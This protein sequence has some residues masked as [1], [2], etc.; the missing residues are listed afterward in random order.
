VSTL[1]LNWK[2]TFK[3]TPTLC[4]VVFRI[5]K[6][7]Q[8]LKISDQ[9]VSRPKPRQMPQLI[10]F[11]VP[12]QQC[13][14]GHVQYFNRL[15]PP[16]KQAIRQSNGLVCLAGPKSPTNAFHIRP[17]ALATQTRRD[18]PSAIQQSSNQHSILKGN[19]HNLF[20]REPI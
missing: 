5:L 20:L 6:S 3:P 18:K 19:R 16:N 10:P 14:T 9:R 12:L 15:W 2:T 7:A 13:L 8:L 17:N 1:Q 4:T 11:P